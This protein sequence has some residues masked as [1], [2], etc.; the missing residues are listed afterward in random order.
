MIK[1]FL[2]YIIEAKDNGKLSHLEHIEDEI[3]NKGYD[4]AITSLD[5]LSDLGHELAGTSDSN[6]IISTKFDGAPAIVAGTN[7]E[8]GKFFVAYKSMK[9]LFYT[10]DDI[11]KVYPSG[12]LTEKYI[13]ALQLLPELGIKDILMGDFLFSS[14]DVK[15]KEIHG[16]NYYTFKPNTI[17]YAVPV[18]SEIGDRV[19][20][21]QIGI[22]FHTSYAGET[23]N[24]LKITLGA[25]VSYLNESRRVWAM[26]ASFEDATGLTKFSGDE[27]AKF[28]NQIK[29]AK[30]SLKRSA[31]VLEQ[32][33][34]TDTNSV[35]FRLKV[36][37]NT[38]VRNNL[39]FADVHSMQRSF[40]EYYETYMQKEIEKRKSERGKETIVNQ[41]V[42]SQKFFNDHK[43]DIYMAIATYVTIHNAKNIIVNKLNKIDS[44]KSFLEI[45]PGEF[46]VTNPEGFVAIRDGGAVKFVDRLN[47]SAANFNIEKTWS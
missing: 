29:M 36:Y 4:G 19:S 26:G 5:M 47:F 37:F 32:L 23:I 38:R 7:P 30:G 12:E 42:A 44:L 27:N 14:K 22:V 11:K 41:L 16:V 34:S 17:T 35:G 46:K 39:K 21:A 45:T 40:E 2:T 31:Q 43:K 9:N 10:V 33:T 3:L 25:N 24:T 13:L 28:Q 15:T 6:I 1:S 20:K 18:D 8:N